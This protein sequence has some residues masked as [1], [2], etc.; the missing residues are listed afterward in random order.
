M[1]E[2]RRPQTQDRGFTLLEVILAIAVLGL[3]FV[4]IVNIT[5]MS[6]DNASRAASELEAR[7]VAESV[8]G[9][10]LAGGRE[11]VS[12]PLAPLQTDLGVEPAYSYA[13]DVEP[14]V[15]PNLL[16]VRVRVT[17]VDATNDSLPLCEIG[18]WKIDPNYLSS[19]AAANTIE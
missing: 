1:I 12:A 19:V 5:R 13:I 7:L 3:S 2:H 6:Y 17:E 11:L 8:M 4:T 18:R 9:E 10:I 15:Q 16:S 14:T